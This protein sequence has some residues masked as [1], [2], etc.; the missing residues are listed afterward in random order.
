MKKYIEIFSLGWKYICDWYNSDANSFHWTI[1]GIFIYLG[2]VV[3]M[4]DDNDL[5]RNAA[6]AVG[7]ITEIDTSTGTP[8]KFYKF[9]VDEVQYTGRDG[10][11]GLTKIRAGDSIIVVYDRTNP[12]NSAI[13]DY[14]QYRLDRSKLPDTV[15]YRQLID[16]QR[17]PLN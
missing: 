2:V 5:S 16:E 7:V 14:F 17:K 4:I 11:G 9:Y 15:Y 13:Y 10:L 6:F 1:F 12:K 3:I 8:G